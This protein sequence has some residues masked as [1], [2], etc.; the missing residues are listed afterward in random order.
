VVVGSNSAGQKIVDAHTTDYYHTYWKMG[1]SS[2][3][4]KYARVRAQWV[5]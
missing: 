4:F 2:T 1:S 3:H 5:V